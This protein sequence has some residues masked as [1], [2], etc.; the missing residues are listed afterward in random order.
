[1][2]KFAVC[3]DES[4]MTD[5]IAERLSEYYP[6]ECEI[7]KYTDGKTLL[8]DSKREDFDAFFL[9]IGM[10]ELNGMALAERIREFN[11][12]VKIIFVTNNNEL[13]HMGYIYDA[14]R[15]VRKSKLEQELFEAAKSLNAYFSSLDEYLNFK[16]PDRTI[17]RSV[18]S[19][20]Y[21]EVNGH[22]VTMICEQCTDKVCGTMKL[23]EERLRNMGF[24]RVHKSY[25]VNMRCIESIQK[26]TVKLANDEV[27]PLSRS[28]AD[29][30]KKKLL[31]FS[32]TAVK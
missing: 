4:E 28:R 32:K 5:Y 29:M 26:N 7:Q 22:T 19:I 15:Y 23:Y 8:S 20:S 6:D 18:N 16:T 25:L 3:D 10:P 24:I 21:F 13:A 9:D 31:D 12:S 2:V 27:L 11:Q 1:M 17:T 14:F 30:V